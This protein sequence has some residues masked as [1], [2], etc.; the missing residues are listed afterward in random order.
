MALSLGIKVG[1]LIHV[2]EHAVKV[3]SV[4]ADII[5]I[6][7][8]GGSPVLVT[9]QKREKILDEVYVSLGVGST[10]TG[11]RLAFDAPRSIPITRK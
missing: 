6:S 4:S 8:D 1:S 5:E 9:E 2:G 11:S 10:G 3:L 7:V